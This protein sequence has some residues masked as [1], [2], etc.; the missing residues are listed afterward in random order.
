MGI[1]HK[2]RVNEG[3]RDRLNTRSSGVSVHSS[4]HQGVLK[5]DFHDD[6]EQSAA[7]H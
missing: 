3:K 5:D 4:S 1:I 6:A 2:K 7:L